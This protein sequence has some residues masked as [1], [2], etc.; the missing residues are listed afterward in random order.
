VS[1]ACGRDVD[2]EVVDRFF[3]FVQPGF[4]CWEW[5]G[6][7][8][9]SGYGQFRLAGKNVGAHRMAWVIEYGSVPDDLCVLHR[10]DNPGCVRVTDLFL[11]TQLDNIADR[12]AKGRS[13]SGLGSGRYTKPER[14]ARGERHGR[15]KLTQED[16]EKI[17]TAFAAGVKNCALAAQYGVSRTQIKHVVR[18]RHWNGSNGLPQL[19]V[20]PTKAESILRGEKHGSAKLTAVDVRQIRTDFAAGVRNYV[21]AAR[22]GVAG[23]HIA[24]IVKRLLWKELS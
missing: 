1:A 5:T 13:A 17:R 18:R 11:G 7:K 14:S 16:V 19:F 6:A 21:L 24:R 22:Y 9:E 20:F 3:A 4:G 8:N 10:C 15:A 12:V 23:T 2:S